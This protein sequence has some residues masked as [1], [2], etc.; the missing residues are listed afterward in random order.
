MN[1]RARF[2]HH[3]ADGDRMEVREGSVSAVFDCRSYYAEE[4]VEVAVRYEDL[5]ELIAALQQMVE[6]HS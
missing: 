5:P 6:D 2:V 4:Q 1:P 3:D